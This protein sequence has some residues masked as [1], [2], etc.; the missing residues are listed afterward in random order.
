MS[1]GDGSTVE[2]LVLHEEWKRHR[3][4]ELSN[5]DQIRAA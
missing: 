5:T 4:V 3:E 2:D 1:Q